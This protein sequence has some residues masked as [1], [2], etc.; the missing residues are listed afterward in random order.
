[1]LERV[2]ALTR[3]YDMLPAGGTVL[4]AVSGGADSI[5]MLHLL[6]SLGE[7]D[8][9]QVAAAHFNHRL[10][11]EESDRDEAFVRRQCEQWSIPL[12]VGAGDVAGQAARL[13]AGVEETARAMRYRFLRA[14]AEKVGACRIATAHNADDNAETLL[15]H[16]VRGTGL[17]GLTGIPPRRGEIVR[18]LLNVTREEIIA[19][20]A[21]RGIDFVEDSSNADEGYTRNYLRRQV[22]PLLRACNPRLSEHMGQTIRS[23]RQDNDY[24][25]AQAYQACQA[26]RW[27]E[28]DLVV[29]AAI[30]AALPN[31]VAPRAVRRLL[32]M[33]GDGE[34]DC[35]AAHLNAVVELCRGEDP[36]AVVFLPH[37]RLAQRVYKEL[38]LTTQSDP[39]TFAPVPLQLEG[40]TA[41]A[42]WV[43]TCRPVTCPQTPPRPERFCLAAPLQGEAVVR[44]RQVGDEICLPHRPGHKRVKRLM[45]DAKLPRRER[46]RVPVLADGAGVLAVAGF[47]PE[48]GR[49]ARPGEAAYE[50]TLRRRGDK[51]KDEENVGSGY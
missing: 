34:A 12:T 4:C 14:T 44:P 29:E 46:E 10:R 35:S 13:G 20:L 42:D 21:Q 3:E 43:I 40:E 2:A 15:L 37:G 39:A 28:D 8:G 51:G 27:A 41:A 16:L 48:E 31:A 5:C 22:M 11:G 24:L 45:I 25:N 32:E 36:S 23:L 47:G 30:I 38:L 49:L 6:R 50:I 26:A 7:R 1:M 9:F 33:M 18:P 17:Q 19:Y